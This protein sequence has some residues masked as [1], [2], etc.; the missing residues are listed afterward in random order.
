M[1][2]ADTE[3][4]VI[5]AHQEKEDMDGMS[6]RFVNCLSVSQPTSIYIDADNLQVEWIQK[7]ISDSQWSKGK[8]KCPSCQLA[9][10]SFNFQN[11]TPC[12]CG[13]TQLPPVQLIVSKV[14]VQK[15]LQLP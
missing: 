11:C 3:I 4:E 5:N 10:G 9:V 1:I 12:C 8:L 15:D 7:E 6:F 2:T 13:Q 14:D